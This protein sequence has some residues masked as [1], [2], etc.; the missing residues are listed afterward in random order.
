MENEIIKDELATINFNAQ[1]FE[2]KGYPQISALLQNICKTV[3][4]SKNEQKY[5]IINL[6]NIVTLAL[7]SA[8]RSKNEN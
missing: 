1:L 7:N 6:C 4:K 8:K 3:E 5:K 2:Q